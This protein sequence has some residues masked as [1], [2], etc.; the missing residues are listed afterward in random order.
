[1]NQ[2]ELTEL[3]RRWKPEKNSVSR[4]YGCYVGNTGEIISQQELPLST[5]P[6]EEAELYFA[7]LKKA[8]SGILGKNLLDVAFST[9]QVMDSDEHRLLQ[10]LRQSELRDEEARTALFQ[11]IIQGADLGESSYLILLA[12]DKYDVP[13]RTRDDG[14]LEDASEQTFRYLLCAV[15]PTK[16]ASLELRY[17]LEARGFHSASSG[18]RPAAPEMGFLFPAFNDRAADLYHALYYTRSSEDVHQS[19]IDSVFHTPALRSAKEQKGAFDAVLQDSLDQD[20]SF[21]LVQSVH[22]QLRTVIQDYTESKNPDPLQL[23]PQEVGVLLK[24][25]GL[26]DEKVKS[27]TAACEKEFGDGASLDPVNIVPGGDPGHPRPKLSPHPHRR[28]RGAQRRQRPFPPHPAGG[29]S[30]VPMLPG[31]KPFRVVFCPF[32]P[33]FRAF[34]G[35]DLAFCSRFPRED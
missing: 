13:A 6:Q 14:E 19:L 1:M 25:S 34:F 12:M 2:R 7:L 8:M 18:V 28:R 30:F 26:E 16:P 20:C 11:R 29:L 21:D 31:R 27:F 33:V 3:R 35:R 15:C 17:D 24:N 32:L 23:S 9:Q 10:A 5:M 4:I 22:E